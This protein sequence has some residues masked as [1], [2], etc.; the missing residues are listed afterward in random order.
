MKLRF[1]LLT[2][3]HCKNLSQVRPASEVM[4]SD[5]FYDQVSTSRQYAHP[6]QVNQQARGIGTNINFWNRLRAICPKEISSHSLAPTPSAPVRAILRTYFSSTAVH[7][8]KLADHQRLL[9]P[10]HFHHAGHSRPRNSPHPFASTAVHSRPRSQARSSP[11]FP[12]VAADIAL[13]LGPNIGKSRLFFFLGYG[14]S[15]SKA[16]FLVRARSEPVAF[17]RVYGA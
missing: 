14:R 13:R 11:F 6:E 4:S 8:A 1:I 15:R 3:H 10:T 17:R 9:L 2:V 5:I 12:S 7:A 16:L